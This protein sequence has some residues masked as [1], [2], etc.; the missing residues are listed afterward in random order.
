MKYKSTAPKISQTEP[1]SPK[2][3]KAK[4]DKYGITFQKIGSQKVVRR[5]EARMTLQESEQ[6]EID[7][8]EADLE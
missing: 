1:P 5:Q 7:E 4:V 3:A 6:P 2:K 8:I